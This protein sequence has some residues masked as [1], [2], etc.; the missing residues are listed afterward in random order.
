M[1]E[2]HQSSNDPEVVKWLAWSAALAPGALDDYAGL[3]AQLRRVT[4]RVGGPYGPAYGFYLAG[5]LA[6]SGQY[7][8][9][10]AE[11][12]QAERHLRPGEANLEFFSAYYDFLLAICHAHLGQDARAR[13]R[14]EAGL[15]QARSLLKPVP[16]GGTPSS[17][18]PWDRK[19]TTRLLQ[20]E[21]ESL[22][23][24]SAPAPAPS[25]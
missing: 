24:P 4:P 6:R 20:E 16:G 25:P 10:V 19:L 18:A 21:A 14:Y 11:F 8:E 15:V 23:K 1:I 5:A 12:E 17:A 22:L 2:R 9:A 7:R 3:I 13:Q